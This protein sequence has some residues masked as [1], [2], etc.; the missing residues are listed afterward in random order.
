MQIPSVFRSLHSPEMPEIGGQ[1]SPTV[2][3]W[4]YSS[5]GDSFSESAYDSSALPANSSTLNDSRS[6]EIRSCRDSRE[7]S[8]RRGET[9]DRVIAQGPDRFAAVCVE[10]ALCLAACSIVDTRNELRA[11]VALCASRR[12]EKRR[13]PT[14]PPHPRGIIS[15][16]HPDIAHP[17]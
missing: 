14:P 8:T 13:R 16:W 3:G 4:R 6:S 2:R 5:R 17:I 9:D 1:S 12:C 7:T 11:A 15:S 10:T